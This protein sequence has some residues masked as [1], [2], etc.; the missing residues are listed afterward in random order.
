MHLAALHSHFM[1]T[2]SQLSKLNGSF[3]SIP[4]IWLPGGFMQ[5]LNT[6]IIQFYAFR[7][8][9]SLADET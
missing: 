3:L 1:T 6:E 4:S 8:S 5:G 9:S 7:V 2:T